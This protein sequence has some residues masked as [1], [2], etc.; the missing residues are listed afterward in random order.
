MRLNHGWRLASLR[1]REGLPVLIAFALLLLTLPS[2]G[3]HFTP[4]GGIV[5]QGSKTI[6][7]PVFINGTFEPY[8]DVDVTKAVVEEFLADGRLQ[9]VSLEAADLVMRG[10]VTKFDLT[11]LSYTPASYVQQYSVSITVDVSIEDAKSQKILWQEKGLNSIFVSSYAV[12]IGDI[13]Q[14]KIAK[15]TAVT[16]A[17]VDIASTLRSRV[18]EG[19]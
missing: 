5:P 17:C 18:L 3:Y 8:I 13:S 10:R 6:A 4:V 7:I 16:N 12:T 1:W 19:F 2:C 11:P 15:E 9:V 14:T